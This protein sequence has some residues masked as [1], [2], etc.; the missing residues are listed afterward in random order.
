MKAKILLVDDDPDMR[1]LVGSFLG[2]NDYEVRTTDSAAGLR[3]FLDA[4]PPDVV[5]LDYKLPDV[6]G[7]P[8]Q[9]IGLTLMPTIRHRWPEAEIII[10]SGHG[11]LDVALEAGRLGAYTFISKPFE[12]G[13]LLADIQCALE[14]KAQQAE[15]S[16]LR[17][18]LATMSGVS[19][20]VFKSAA[21]QAV[22]RTVERIA[23]T[24]VTVLI[25]GESGTGKEVVADLLHS[26]SRRNKNR[27]IK[28]NCAALPRELIES[29][30]FGSVKGA[31]T[32]AHA[33]REGLFRQAEG[34]TL[35]LDEIAEMPVDTQSK[36]L[37]VLQDQEVRPVGGKTTYKTNCRIITATNRDPEEAIKQGKLREDLYY[38]IST[39]SIHLPPLRER[40]DD[41]L[42]LAQSF[43]RR[44]S[45][46]ANR[47]INGFT[48]AAIDRL[49]NFDWPGNVRQLQNEIQR[50]VLLSDGPWID[51][52]DLSIAR[53]RA[54][55]DA[56]SDTNFTLLEGV[57]R[58]TIIQTLKE[59][60]GNKVEAA[61]RL[62]IG[63]QTL[64]NK[65][66]AYGIK[67]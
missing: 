63:R 60:G 50:A 56:G 39:V 48:P 59:T 24:D 52:A 23:P 34:G 22:I 1:E 5:L 8:P 28:V 31:Y 20:P 57:E 65:I 35:F 36:L 17:D 64:Y 67:I 33:D 54:G 42:P 14:H 18:A 38:R 9:D 61:R 12:L 10:L 11:T 29:E 44:F 25:T 2:Q 32:G 66:K 19:S 46:Q 53:S 13:K 15:N 6:P 26:L 41:I 16:A 51:A 37:R 55:E 45:A 3:G 40:R 43:L 62:G 47:I 7:E 49:L 58:N 27:I 30:L 21:M 4:E